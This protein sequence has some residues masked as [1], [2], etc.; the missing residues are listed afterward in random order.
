MGFGGIDELFP[1]L[2][3]VD[4]E[5]MCTVPPLLTAYQGFDAL[6]HSVEGYISR[7]ANLMSDMY[8]LT[9]IE[10]VA[11]NLARA[12]KTGMT[13]N[14]RKIAFGSTLS[15]VVMCISSCTSEHS[16][17]HAMSAY[18]QELPHGAGLL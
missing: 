11:R 16:M 4:P 15:G 6:F 18:H 8:A 13:L 9:A 12:V 7:L 3:I 1:V 17:E 5:L 10:N 2:A 14:P